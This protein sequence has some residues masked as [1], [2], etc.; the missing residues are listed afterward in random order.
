MSKIDKREALHEYYCD[1]FC[2]LVFNSEDDC[3]KGCNDVTDF[4]DTV[5]SI[6][7][8]KPSTANREAVRRI[9]QADRELSEI[10]LGEYEP[11]IYYKQ[12][13]KET[14]SKILSLITPEPNCEK[15]GVMLAAMDVHPKTVEPK[16][17]SASE[18]YNIFSD[19]E[20]EYFA[21]HCPDGKDIGTHTM[22]ERATSFAC[23]A[24]SQA[25]VDKNK[26]GV[27]DGK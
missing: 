19:A 23:I 25:T 26:E 2:G 22:E 8:P 10:Q 16:V 12:D 18:C 11:F 13:T 6:T 15:C 9:I 5:L 21:K 1:N 20:R 14:V 17:L 27:E 7:D 3:C 4:I 24:I